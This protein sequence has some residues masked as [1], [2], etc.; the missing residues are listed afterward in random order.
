[1]YLDTATEMLYGP[2]TQAGWGSGVSLIGPRG[3]Q[4]LPGLTG[5]PG[6]PGAQGP[7][8]VPGFT[9]SVAYAN[10]GQYTYTVPSGVTAIEIKHVFRTGARCEF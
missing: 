5:R 7:P 2:L 3:N 10:P 1:M 9:A 6:S 4:A 8:G